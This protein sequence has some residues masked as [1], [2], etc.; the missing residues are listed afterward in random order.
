VAQ[1]FTKAEIQANLKMADVVALVE[2]GFKL[3]ASGKTIIPPFGSLNLPQ[4]DVHIK[5][6]YIKESPYYVVKA[7][8]HFP[9]SAQASNGI[10][11][12]C[13]SR[14]GAVEGILL[15]EGYLTDIRTAA[16]G[17]ICAKYMAPKNVTAIGIVGCG[18]QSFYQLQYLLDMIECNTVYV[19]GR[20]KE[21]LA[22]FAG[23]AEFAHL[24][25]IQTQSLETLADA[26]NLIVTATGSKSPLL[27]AHH[28]KPGTHITAVGADDKGKQEIEAQVFSKA[29]IVVVDSKEQCFEYGDSSYALQS[30]HLHKDNVLELGE[31]IRNPAA[32]RQNDA[33]ITICDLTGVA[34]QDIQIATHVFAHLKSSLI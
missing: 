19:Y 9:E 5:Y 33:Q 28:I 32:A 15:D 21:R 16:A 7:A 10:M 23:H 8:S 22:A 25:L 20:N 27:Y 12:V 14:T 17:A 11:L 2:E 1:V 13:C 26:C 6:G 30:G 34:I 24:N 3:A 4:G 29:D 18:T 31:I